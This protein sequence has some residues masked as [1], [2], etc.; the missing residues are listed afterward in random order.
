MLVWLMPHLAHATTL[1][2]SPSGLHVAPY[3]NWLNA[4]TN[5][6]DALDEANNGDSVIVT[7]GYYNVTNELTISKPVYLKGS[8]SPKHDSTV[9]AV[10]QTRIILIQADGVTVDGF[11]LLNG[12]PVEWGGAINAAD[13]DATIRNCLIIS[14]R[15][16]N[17]SQNGGG[18]YAGKQIKVENCTFLYNHADDYGG[19]IF[20]LQSFHAIR[21]CVMANNTAGHSGGAIACMYSDG[22]IESCTI[23]NNAAGS[24]GGI[25]SIY[26]EG[27]YTYI[28]NSIIYSNYPA[29]S[30][31]WSNC[32]LYYSCVV[33][34]A[35]VACITNPPE[36][37]SEYDD[38]YRL[39]PISPCINAGTNLLWMNTGYDLDFKP[40]IISNRVDV[41]AYELGADLRIVISD[42]EHP[43]LEWNSE[44]NCSYQ[45]QEVMHLNTGGWNNVGVERVGSGIPLQAEIDS[46][47]KSTMYFRVF[48]TTIP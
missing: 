18:L 10:G 1:Y 31:N 44:S 5:I 14:N 48:K 4:A 38:D 30:A 39:K 17:S 43:Y 34:E 8:S 47:E 22:V 13:G 20:C 42:C 16:A 2:V 46:L 29:N 3:T 45:V 35:G 41:G 9:S 36:F 6:Q 23:M 7:S 40:R 21:N 15:A 32:V 11:T 19:A 27:L 28:Y 12:N 26:R 25:V 33:P 37:V 24:E